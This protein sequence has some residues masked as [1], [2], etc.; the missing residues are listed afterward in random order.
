[1][2]FKKLFIAGITGAVVFFF[3]GWLFYDIILVDYL[4]NNPG[5]IGLIGRKSPLYTYLIVGQLLY[6]FLLAYILI[7]ANVDTIAGGFTNGAIIG[8][9]MAGAV[10][11][12]MYSTSFILSKKGLAADVLASSLITAVAAALIVAVVK[13]K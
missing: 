9:L 10:N 3:L 6:G 5:N 7:K 13:K 4:R 1:M 8:F 12:T 11:F 2:D